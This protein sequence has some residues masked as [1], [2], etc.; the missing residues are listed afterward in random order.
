VMLA[1]LACPAAPKAQRKRTEKDAENRMNAEANAFMVNP[2]T[3]G[4]ISKRLLSKS[5]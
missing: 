2:S 3:S 1:R 5:N 4:R